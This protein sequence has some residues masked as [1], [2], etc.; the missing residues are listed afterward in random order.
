[1]T[2]TLAAPQLSSNLNLV[3]TPDGL[4]VGNG[5]SAIVAIE[6]STG[7]TRWSEDIYDPVLWA[8]ACSSLAVAPTA[9]RLYC[10][11]TLGQIIERELTTGHPTGVSFDTQLGWIGDVATASD[12]RELVAFGGAP[13]ISRWRLDGSGP[14]VDRIAEGRTV[15]SGYDPTGKMLLTGTDPAV[16]DPASD[17]AIDELEGSDG[18]V[19][20]GRGTL[21]GYFPDGN[22]LYDVAA[23]AT[24]PSAS[25]PP[26]N[27]KNF[28]WMSA[29]GHRAYNSVVQDDPASGASHCE[30]WTYDPDRRRRIAPTI[31]LDAELAD[32]CSF[33]THVSATRDGE[34]IVVTTGTANYR[35]RRTTVYDGRTGKQVAGPLHGP[36]VTS[37]SPDGVLV[38]GDVSGG[39][40]RYDVDTLKPIGAFPG[41][42]N[43]VTQ[44]RFSADGKI[45]VASSLNQTLSIYAVETSTRLGDPIGNDFPFLSGS[46]RPDGKAVATNAPDGVAIWD[47]DPAH[48][49]RTACEVAGRNLT[50][51]EWD[52]Y[53]GDPG[54][55]RA[56]CPN[57]D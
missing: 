48:L 34:R 25:R 43:L 31:K 4:L 7:A 2:R 13:V 51:T 37:V 41:T 15:V 22:N 47:I 33:D 38:G 9:Q 54:D 28:A 39:I 24:V 57:Y 11:N 12:G 44:L 6:T 53:F 32:D 52:T 19:W 3:V 29:D 56:T 18:A 35:S 20:F 17:K 45:L 49:A 14:A 16:W 21:A 26:S 23:H 8:R 27:P 55:R 30:I 42:Q 40:T 1:V 10:A 50:R 36:I 5:R 46:I